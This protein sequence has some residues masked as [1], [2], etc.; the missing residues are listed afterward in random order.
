MV[1]MSKRSR[2]PRAAITITQLDQLCS[3]DEKY[4]YAFKAGFF[5][6][7]RLKQ[8]KKLRSG[9]FEAGREPSLLVRRNK[10]CRQGRK[11]RGDQ[12]H[13]K[14]VLF[15]ELGLV[16]EPM[17]EVFDAGTRMFNWVDDNRARWLVKRAAR[18]FKWPRRKINYDG[19]HC[20]RHGGAREAKLR[21]LFAA[22]RCAN[23]AAMA[24]GTFAVGIFPNNFWMGATTALPKKSFYVLRKRKR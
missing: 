6:I 5:G 22:E 7:L 20:C 14:E 9:D 10:R 17:Q 2:T 15:E 11:P 3:L 24:R 1:H 4:G 12:K 23:G 18:V 19:F 16:L 8:L 13:R 21:V